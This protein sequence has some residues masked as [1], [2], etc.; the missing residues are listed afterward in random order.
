[1]GEESW[2]AADRGKPSQLEASVAR[3]GFVGTLGNT[4]DG[5]GAEGGEERRFSH[6]SW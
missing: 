6:Q 2:V 1:M 4:G 5:A 3:T